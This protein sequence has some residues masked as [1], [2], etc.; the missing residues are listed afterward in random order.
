MAGQGQLF[1]LVGEPGIGKTRLAEELA[2]RVAAR[3]SETLWGRC[4]EHGGAPPFWPWIQ[5][6]RAARAHRKLC[7]PDA[8]LDEAAG[9][10]AQFLPEIDERCA[11][12]TRPQWDLVDPQNRFPLFDAVA[13]YLRDLTRRRPLLL[14]LDDLHAADTPSLLLLEFLAHERHHTPLCIIGTYREVELGRHPE[15][16]AVMSRAARA[17]TRIPLAGLGALDVARLIE[18]RADTPSAPFLEA[19]LRHTEGNP[20]FIDEIVRLWIAQSERSPARFAADSSLQIPQS[21]REAVSERLRTLSST[22]RT[23]LALAAVLGREFELAPL[24]RSGQLASQVLLEHLAEATVA[25]IVS[26]VD[27]ERQR[28]SFVHALFRESLYDEIAPDERSRMH[29]RVG[30][31]L[32]S[33]HAS[34]LEPHL[35]ELAYHF[36]QAADADRDKAIGYATRAGDRANTQQAY[37]DAVAHYQGALLLQQRSQEADC[38]ERQCEL[39]L[40][41]GAA[42]RA[43]SNEDAKETFQRAAALARRCL[44]NGRSGAAEWL[45]RAALGFADR[46]IGT[47]QLVVDPE[48]LALVDE[49]LSALPKQDSPLRARLLARLAMERSFDEDGCVGIQLSQ[50][51]VDMAHRLGDHSTLAATL[52]C[53]QFVLWRVA[54]IRDRLSTSTDIIHLAERAGDK[55][56]AL[57]GRSWRLVDLMGIGEVHRFDAEIEAQAAAAKALRQPRYEWLSVNLRAMRALWA[58]HWQAAENLALQSLSLGE[59]TGDQAA[60]I[61]PWIQIFFAKREQGLLAEQEAVTRLGAAQFPDSPVP[62]TLLSIL[63]LDL[64]RHA[65]AHELYETLAAED[66]D[67]LR[68]QR[69]VGVLPFLAELCTAFADVRRAALLYRQL[70]PFA[71]GIVPYGAVANFAAGA[72]YLALLAAAQGEEEQARQHF[73]IAL[74]LH[75]RTE[76]RAWLAHTCYEYARFLWRVDGN[77]RRPYAERLAWQALQTATDLEMT[78]LAQKVVVLRDEQHVTAPSDACPEPLPPPPTTADALVYVFRLDGDYWS[79]GDSRYVA[80]LKDILGMRYLARLLRHPEHDL[81]SSELVALESTPDIDVETLPFELRWSDESLHVH[82]PG[83]SSETHLD[84]SAKAAYRRRLEDLR[85]DLDEATRFNDRDRATRARAEIEF[86][87]QELS[88]ALGLGERDRP[89]AAAAERARLNVTRA[90]KS[91]LKR[92]RHCHPALGR[93]LETTI[94]TGTYCSYTPDPR[95][96]VQWHW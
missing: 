11:R 53:R 6:L 83:G 56:L 15:R 33:L 21:V 87:V 96:P 78:A 13:T 60:A 16:L 65:E 39:W 4:W 30:E 44:L 46:G 38:N 84:R 57:Q 91:A 41:L 23:T 10:L 20:F 86:L 92:I 12:A 58:G 94:K 49:A 95:L 70:L 24:A 64:G 28:Y 73:D 43:A 17:G 72:H 74:E 48:V 89:V 9:P 63:C 19:V 5:I 40:R 47:P 26:H 59:R 69:R 35:A 90:I 8:G 7:D 31:G 1:L 18:L 37:E 36:E 34:D 2:E 71:R 25:G 67:N 79:I 55:A 66:F 54:N 62:Q 27:S 45:A 42:Q 82:S 93:Y 80:R 88:R 75:Q 50:D 81:L 52:S 76:A 29:H 22:C 3:G 51:A 61:S 14:I 77:D 68:R 85:Q 32:E